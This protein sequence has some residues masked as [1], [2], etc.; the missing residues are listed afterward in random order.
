MLSRGT[1]G[2]W[3]SLSLEAGMERLFWER[4]KETSRLTEKAKL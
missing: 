1:R 2:V 3:L 4:Q